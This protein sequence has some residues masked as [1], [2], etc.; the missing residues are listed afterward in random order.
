MKRLRSLDF[1]SDDDPVDL[2]G[3]ETAGGHV[4]TLSLLGAAV[5]VVTL[6]LTM[7]GDGLEEQ[8]AEG[9]T[10]AA[11]SVQSIVVD[12]TTAEVEHARFSSIP[13]TPVLREMSSHPADELSPYMNPAAD[14]SSTANPHVVREFH[15]L[16]ALFSKRQSEDDNFTVRVID[17]R[18]DELLEV[19]VLDDLRRR[20]QNGDSLEW[21]EV[22][23]HRREATRR[24]VDKYE[25]QGVPVEDIMVRW[26]RANQVRQA[27]QSNRPYQ[28]YE[29]QL[30][31]YLDLSL[32]PTQ[33]GVVE[34]FNQDDLV[35]SAGA[36]SRYQ[37]MPWIL[38]RSG[39][40]EYTLRTQEGSTVDVEEAH[41]PLLTL[42]P[43]FLLLKGYINA[44]GHE[45]PGLSAYHTGPGNIFK[46]YRQYFTKSSLYR[47]SSTVVD[48]YV[49]ALTEGFETVREGSSFGPF[50]RGYVP[51]AYGA[52]TAL[53][54]RPLDLSAS[55]RT[56]RVQ[57]RP[58]TQV[59]LDSLL[60]VLDTTAYAFDWGPAAS[61]ST[62]YERFRGLNRHLDL[63]P[64][65]DEGVPAA[66]N[67]QL[68]STIDG[69]AVRFFL[70]LGA[71]SALRAAG[72]DV[73]DPDLSFRF[74]SSTFTPPS[75]EQRTRW[76]REY[77]ALVANIRD[78]GFTRENRKT[79]LELHEKFEALAE[80]TPTRYRK[81]QLDVISTHRRIWL[82]NP[83][84]ELS[85]LTMQMT[86]RNA[87]PAQPP[88]EIPME[89]T[90][91][92]SFFRPL[93]FSPQ[94]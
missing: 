88:I 56:V 54:R 77:D 61:K 71:P 73:V 92:P 68:V 76:D 29:I 13:A 40:N 82:S 26:G 74:D 80:E 69:K 94:N 7:S 58:G 24:L 49:W 45:I 10:R 38:R 50:S 2:P 14:P 63:P 16:L 67:V 33:M 79:L 60:T 59:S 70:P 52:L 78:F 37:M 64:T 55:I 12:T 46:L 17:R 85:D 34:T 35:S 15:D 84:V 8:V 25:A 51:S 30:A 4:L 6:S 72:L 20:H 89:P 81:R 3:S 47:P 53:D 48:A 83:W 32:L 11:A 9:V 22:D 19:Y 41:H 31:H 87:V 28:A 23:Q 75:P 86:G 42:E 39:V 91:S 36:R 66:G 57:L 62:T 1:F 90:N 27:Q 5:L 43:A 65:T 93:P 21:R 18:T 44:V